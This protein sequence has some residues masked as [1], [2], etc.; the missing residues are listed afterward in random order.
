MQLEDEK[1]LREHIRKIIRHHQIITEQT[2]SDPFDGDAGDLYDIFVKPFTQLFDVFKVASKDV[3]TSAKFTWDML[4]TIDPVKK[5]TLKKN[6]DARKKKIDSDYAE[7]MK[8]FKESSP[9]LDVLTFFLAPGLSIPLAAGKAGVKS[10]EGL[11]DFFREAGF[12]DPSDKEKEDTKDKPDKIKDPKGIVG[13]AI[14]RLAGL[15]FGESLAISH[16]GKSILIEE[17]SPDEVVQVID[18][19]GIMKKLKPGGDDLQANL[20]A[21]VAEIEAEIGP[22]YEAAYAIRS[23]KNFDELGKA[24]SDAKAAG[25]DVGDINV[26][27][28]KANVDADVKRLTDPNNKE[29]V[30][31]NIGEK[32]KEKLAKMSPEEVGE[33]LES[34]I[35]VAASDDMR[36][37]ISAVTKQL[38]ESVQD[39][40]GPYM[41]KTEQS[42]DMLKKTAAGKQ[43]I[44]TLNDFLKK[45]GINEV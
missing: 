19:F 7:V 8:P 35:F 44:E 18:D 17:A 14:D 13:T 31:G 4:V 41:P 34:S 9:D 39:L 36:K 12:G 21:G 25:F 6:Y 40:I 32:E 22:Q 43:Y 2:Y 15:F 24:L 1:F 37:N 30:L 5:R 28:I 11:G 20:E 3:L 27:E 10:T 26:A 45:F 16:K 33:G 42:A 23:S 38:Q 29:E